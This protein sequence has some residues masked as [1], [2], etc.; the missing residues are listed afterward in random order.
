MR[1]KSP[2]Y[3]LIFLALTA[4][5]LIACGAKG[6]TTVQGDAIFETRE[7]VGGAEGF[8]QRTDTAAEIE[9]KATSANLAWRTIEVET[10]I[11]GTGNRV[12]VSQEPNQKWFAYVFLPPSATEEG[13]MVVMLRDPD[14][15]QAILPWDCDITKIFLEQAGISDFTNEFCS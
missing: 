8:F 9:A 14:E 12:I 15:A 10:F 11:G 2:A 4:F 1:R 6:T 13:T 3:L 7:L 5:V